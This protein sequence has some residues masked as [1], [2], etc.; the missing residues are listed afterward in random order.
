MAK[1]GLLMQRKLREVPP[2]V[3]RFYISLFLFRWKLFM[4]RVVY[5]FHLRRGLVVVKNFLFY[6]LYMRCGD[7]LVN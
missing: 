7:F 3:K 6:D 5:R 2:L 1:M 4:D